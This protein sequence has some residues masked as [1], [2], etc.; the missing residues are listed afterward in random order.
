MSEETKKLLDT[1]PVETQKE[2]LEELKNRHEKKSTA[3]KAT[4]EEIGSLVDKILPK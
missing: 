3:T 1:I 2:L 4:K